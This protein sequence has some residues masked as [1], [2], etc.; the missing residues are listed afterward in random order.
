[1]IFY[2]VFKGN[3]QPAFRFAPVARFT[4]P[5]KQAS[6]PGGKFC[7]PCEIKNPQYQTST[8]KTNFGKPLADFEQNPG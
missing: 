6:K 8:H 3:I 5:T 2:H 7:R 4:Y 1:M